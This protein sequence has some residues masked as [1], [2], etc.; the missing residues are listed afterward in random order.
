[1]TWLGITP[2]GATGCGTRPPRARLRAGSASLFVGVGFLLT[3]FRV[4]AA[5]S[6]RLHVA[7]TRLARIVGAG[8]TAFI[9]LAAAAAAGLVGPVLAAAR[10]AGIPG[11][12]GVAAIALRLL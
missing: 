7:V 12:A 9:A 10:A 1:M 8:S 5:R 2:P 6:A 11:G 4:G 3:G